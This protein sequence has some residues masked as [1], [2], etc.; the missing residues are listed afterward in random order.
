MILDDLYNSHGITSVLV[1]TGPTM[2]QAFID[3]DLW[4]IA[5]V[6]VSPKTLGS[7]GTCQSPHI[8]QLPEGHFE[9]GNNYVYLFSN[10]T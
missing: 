9:I 3:N 10:D 1:E 2:L 8:N 5:R 6:E 7:S 4:D